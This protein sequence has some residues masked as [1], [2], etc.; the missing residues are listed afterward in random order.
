MVIGDLLS[1]HLLESWVIFLAIYL[2]QIITEFLNYC[3]ELINVFNKTKVSQPAGFEPARGDPIGFQVQRHNH[4]ATTAVYFSWWCFV[5][6][7]NW[8]PPPIFWCTPVV[9]SVNQENHPGQLN[10]WQ[11]L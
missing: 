4:S 11:Y 8:T 3:C 2:S 7:Q 10:V 1:S 5:N 9:N 6:C